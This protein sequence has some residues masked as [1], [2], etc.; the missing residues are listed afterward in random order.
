M[1]CGRRG[2]FAVESL[3]VAWTKCC[4]MNSSDLIPSVLS[5]KFAQQIGLAFGGVIFAPLGARCL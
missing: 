1:T 5:L 4:E 3:H 2:K